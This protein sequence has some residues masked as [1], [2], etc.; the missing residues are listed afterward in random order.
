MRLLSQPEAS[1][2]K[3]TS[4]AKFARSPC[5]DPPGRSLALGTSINL[6]MQSVIRQ[7]TAYPVQEK[8]KMRKAKTG[9]R[10]NAIRS[11]SDDLFHAA[12]EST[13]KEGEALVNVLKGIKQML[14]V[15]NRN[16]DTLSNIAHLSSVVA[17]RFEKL[18]I[19][20]DYSGVCVGS[21]G[22]YPSILLQAGSIPVSSAKLPRAR[23]RL[24]RR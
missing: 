24:Y 23:S 5:T 14:R 16:D 22:Q 3:R 4:I 19:R 18:S 10:S 15:A 21:G 20:A 17:L 1:I 9:L 7:M 2:Q 6:K 11:I 13:A 8:G 12:F